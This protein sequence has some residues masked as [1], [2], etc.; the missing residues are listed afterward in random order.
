MLKEIH[1]LEDLQQE[2]FYTREDKK[3]VMRFRKKL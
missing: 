3:V 1:F 2:P